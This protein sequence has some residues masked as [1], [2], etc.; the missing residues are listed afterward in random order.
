MAD[1]IEK[2]VRRAREGDEAAFTA[3]YGAFATRLYRFFCFRVPSPELAEDLTQ[4]VFVK[5]IEQLP[6]YRHQGAP[7][8]AWV[9][10]IARNVWIDQH[11][12]SHP[13][14]PLESLPESAEGQPGPEELALRTLD[15]ERVTAGLHRLPDD[16]REV[17][18][19]RFFAELSPAETAALMGRSE[20]SVRVTQHRALVALRRMLAP[21]EVAR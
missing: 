1:E 6:N 19:C 2:L 4:Q 9:F 3:I 10:R 20:G 13:A 15:L 17:V 11:R 18:V 8:A 14:T 21:T 16:Q 7:F 12:T 5:M